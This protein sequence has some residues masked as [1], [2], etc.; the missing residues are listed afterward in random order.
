MSQLGREPRRG[1]R[2]GVPG[3]A[4]GPRSRRMPRGWCA[5]GVR[6]FRYTHKQSAGQLA[7]FT[8]ER[9]V[10]A[11]VVLTKS[12]RW[13]SVGLFSDQGFVGCAVTVKLCTDGGFSFVHQGC[14][15]S[16]K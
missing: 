4:S 9:C 8:D 10:V 1:W 2:G 5:V 16:D 14:F 11:L 7:V 6:L 13:P 3:A 12:G 15:G